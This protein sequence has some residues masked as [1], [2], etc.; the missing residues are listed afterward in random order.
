[1]PCA[2]SQDYNYCCSKDGHGLKY[3]GFSVVFI[4]TFAI[5]NTRQFKLPNAFKQDL[6][7]G[8]DFVFHETERVYEGKADALKIPIAR[9]QRNIESQI[10]LLP[11]ERKGLPDDKTV[12]MYS[13]R[14]FDLDRKSVV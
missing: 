10:F 7:S 11:E 9:M 4:Q 12:R 1:M 2:T 8:E 14:G 6:P 5:N 3:P 13:L